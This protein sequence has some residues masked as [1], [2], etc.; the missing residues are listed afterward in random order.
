MSNHITKLSKFLWE[1]IDDLLIG[2]SIVPMIVLSLCTYFMSIKNTTLII[3]VF[4]SSVQILSRVISK[5]KVTIEFQLYSKLCIL[6]RILII[7]L[8]LTC[9]SPV[10]ICARKT[11]IMS[12]KVLPIVYQDRTSAGEHIRLRE[13][14]GEKLNND[15]V[16]YFAS[17]LLNKS[18]YSIVVSY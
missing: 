14:K 10:D 15:F 17:P 3:I 2:S 9:F 11:G 12:I 18:C 13:K 16:V 7:G 6:N 5:N 1:A 4:A 8:L